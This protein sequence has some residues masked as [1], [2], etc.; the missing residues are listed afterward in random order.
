MVF[1]SQTSSA[2]II[3]VFRTNYYKQKANNDYPIYQVLFSG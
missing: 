2:I 1:I 3:A